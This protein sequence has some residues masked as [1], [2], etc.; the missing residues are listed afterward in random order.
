[1]ADDAS[2]LGAVSVQIG[3]N[4]SPMEQTF[5]R[6]ESLVRAWDAR[7]ANG[8]SG[9]VAANLNGINA[10]VTQ[11][12]A[13][14]NRITA[15][16]E[17]AAAA[18]RSINTS[19]GVTGGYRATTADIEAYGK[20]LDDVR[21]KFNPLFAAERQHNAL[22]AEMV[23]AAKAGAISAEELFA[24]IDRQGSA[25]QRQVA[26]INAS[27][28]AL[29]GNSFQV[30]NLGFQLNDV[31]TQL[32][33]GTNAWT[34][35]VQ[36]GPQI[37]QAFGRT[38]AA[39]AMAMLGEAF[40]SVVNPLSLIT[41]GV[42]AFGG[43]AIQMLGQVI[44]KTESATDAL[45]R[46]AKELRTI[47]AGYKDAGTAVEDYVQAAQTLP[48]QIVQQGIAQQFAQLKQ[49]AE[50]F[51]A[52][53]SGE[54]FNLFG[55]QNIGTFTALASS[56][57]AIDRQVGQLGVDFSQHKI[58]VDEFAAGMDKVSRMNFFDPLNGLHNIVTQA[59]DAA[60]AFAGLQ[61]AYVNLESATAATGHN[62]GVQVALDSMLASKKSAAAQQVELAAINALSP[63]QQADIAR[64]RAKL[65][66]QDQ[67]MT[68]ALRNQK[69]DEAGALAYAQAA[70]A[71]TTA[72][73]M[74]L[75]AA[76]QNIASAKTDLS[77]I[78]MSISETQR[79]TFVRQQLASA[80]S[81][82]AQNGVSV[83]AAY[84]A[85]IKEIGAAYGELQQKIA[86][87]KAMSDAVFATSQFGRTSSEQGIASTLRGIYG[88]DFASQM[89][90][91]IA[92][93]LRYNDAL[94]QGQ[95]LAQSFGST[96]INDFAQGKSVTET[97][98]D[99]VGNLGQQ[100]LQIALNQAIA[101]LFSN[102]I[103]GGFGSIAGGAAIPSGGFIPGLTGPKLFDVGGYT[104]NGGRMQPAGIVHKGEYVFDAAST[105][106]IGVARLNSL[107]GYAA[108]GLVGA[109]GN[110]PA[111]A[112]SNVRD[113]HL[114]FAFDLSGAKPGV[115]TELDQWA[116]MQLPGIVRKI[117]ND[118]H[119]VG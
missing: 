109:N 27:N 25:Y 54:K 43:T 60:L 90:G 28:A 111:A 47:V 78:G 16:A 112:N 80:E 42:I 86:E 10:M 96:L 8:V 32:S 29:K 57:N 71:I 74:R 20:A 82:A 46:H 21:A 81:E 64:R 63:A 2:L 75:L 7:I 14:L 56:L 117:V 34:V 65:D 93:Q 106:R 15:P 102:L 67:E 70:N 101:S 37:T 11:T 83:S 110:T 97:L 40:A 61:T 12:T 1:M 94:A 108:G 72:D 53:M 100:L 73:R 9:A 4:M 49:Q 89:D 38:G 24:A 62:Q 5:A 118:P 55:G 84:I 99:A 39:G 48:R 107:R 35:A 44:P 87:S 113:V 36:Q 103:G 41:L 104:G 59:R 33:A 3:A 22:L 13:S 69:I 45:D 66:L 77:T 85:K 95:Q 31:F 58:S 116:R 18:L 52:T 51:G 19:T 91:A 50:E 105:S 30:A 98:A 114:H 23:Q 119:A 26:G 92:Q 88:D 6:A 68:D 17:K 76:N 115:S 79:L